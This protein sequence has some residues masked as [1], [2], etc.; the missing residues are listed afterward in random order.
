MAKS[1]K[2]TQPKSLPLEWSFPEGLVSRY[3]NNIM[4]QHSRNEFI[5]SFFETRPPLLIGTVDRIER[6]KSETKAI[7]AEC[8]AR[9]VVSPNKMRDFIKVLNRNIE[10]YE[11]TFGNMAE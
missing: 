6:V 7:A 2:T 5:V 9:I 3:A 10:T 1:K 8:V 11:E 4:V